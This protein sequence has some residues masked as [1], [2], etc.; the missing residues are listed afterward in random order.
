M[1][2]N[3]IETDLLQSSSTESHDFYSPQ[4]HLKNQSPFNT[5]SPELESPVSQQDQYVQNY[6]EYT[7]QQVWE[8]E[9]DLYDVSDDDVYMNESEETLELEPESSRSRQALVDMR[10]VVALQAVQQQRVRGIR[11]F[12]DALDHENTL[13]TY[14][15]TFQSTPLKDSKTALVFAH[16]VN[17]TGPSL[18]MFERHPANPAL[19]FIGSTVPTN[20][21]HIWTCK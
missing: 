20:Q 21:R 17:V 7:S 12:A 2:E 6:P 11:S 10:N 18:S 16:F 15:P 1:H 9:D 19:M 13:S 4:P 5:F 3:S 14:Q 8:E